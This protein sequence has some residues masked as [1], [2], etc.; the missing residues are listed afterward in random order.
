[1][2]DDRVIDEHL[3]VV[4]NGGVLDALYQAEQVAWS[5]DAHSTRLQPR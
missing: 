2:T 5:S 1:M 3:G 4:L